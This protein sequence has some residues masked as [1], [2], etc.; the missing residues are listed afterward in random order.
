MPDSLSSHVREIQSIAAVPRMLETV[1]ALTGLRFVCI[2]H[3]T[4]TS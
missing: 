3:V 2:A 4:A 1:A